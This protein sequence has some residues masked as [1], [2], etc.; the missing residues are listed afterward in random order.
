MHPSALVYY[1][2]SFEKYYANEL[3]FESQKYW[4]QKK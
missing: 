4:V 3:S 2:P 1:H